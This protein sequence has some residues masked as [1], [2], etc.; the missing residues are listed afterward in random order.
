MYIIIKIQTH[1]VHDNINN[2]VSTRITDTMDKEA[3]ANNPRDAWKSVMLFS[4]EKYAVK[5]AIDIHTQLYWIQGGSCE[6]FI[7]RRGAGLWMRVIKTVVYQSGVARVDAQR[8][9]S[10][11]A[12]AQ[13]CKA[14]LRY[15][16]RFPFIAI[17]YHPS[18]S[19]SITPP[20]CQ[21]SLNSSNLSY[22]CISTGNRRKWRCV[23]AMCC[24][25]LI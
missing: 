6:Y 14:I 24:K 2:I 8:T 4:A 15:E 13:R 25:N 23:I 16:R 1:V 17:I 5:W 19:P 20:L 21:R 3:V 7:W 18:N 9:F 10:T 11:A 22:Y 12:A